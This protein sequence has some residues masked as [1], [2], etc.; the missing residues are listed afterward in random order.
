MADPA[1]VATWIAVV[2]IA[3]L[4][5]TASHRVERSEYLVTSFF[6]IFL[7]FFRQLYPTHFSSRSAC[8]PL[9]LTAAKGSKRRY[10]AAYAGFALAAIFLLPQ[11]V[12][13]GLFSEL[14]VIVVGAVFPL[15]ESIRAVCT[16]QTGDDMSWLQYWCGMSGIFFTASFFNDYFGEAE[17]FQ[18]HFHMFEFFYYLWLVLPFTDGS[19]LVFD[20]FTIPMLSPVIKP[21]AGKMGTWLNGIVM[22][23]VNAS[24]LWLLWVLFVILP[25]FI[26]RFAAIGVG[27]IYP[28]LASVVA[29]TTSQSEDDAFWL[30]YWSCYGALFLIVDWSEEWLGRVPGFYVLV[31]FTE[32]Y[33][34]LP[35]FQG[36]EKV[37]RHVLVPIAGL[38]EMLLLRD[39]VMVKKDLLRSIPAGRQAAV[40]EAIAKAF[41]EDNEDAIFEISGGAAASG[42][43]SDDSSNT[44]ASGR[45]GALAS[46]LHGSDNV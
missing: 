37:F 8:Q 11:E 17:S 16:P 9:H 36:A 20:Y 26:K 21:V 2:L 44:R 5:V 29:V 14:G 22:T 18:Y 42:G 45:Y 39:A 23:F 7:G 12:K 38:K 6:V 28:A 31:I 33:L 27:T 1:V 40:R 43:V 41:A 3:A 46:L 10:H 13:D 24:H 4:I 25:S 30:T 15:Y 34:M 19:T 32:L 35:M